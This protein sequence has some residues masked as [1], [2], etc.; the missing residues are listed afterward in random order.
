MILEFIARI[1]FSNRESVDKQ[2]QVLKDVN[3]EFFD[4][5]IYHVDS[6]PIQSVHVPIPF[7]GAPQAMALGPMVFPVDQVGY[8]KVGDRATVSS[9]DPMG[10]HL[11]R[12]ML[13]TVTAV[14]PVNLLIT[15]NIDTL[16]PDVGTYAPWWIGA[17]D[18]LTGQLQTIPQRTRFSVTAV[19]PQATADTGQ[20]LAKLTIILPQI[21]YNPYQS[22]STVWFDGLLFQ[23]STEAKTYFDGSG[24]PQPTNP[25]TDVFIS[26]KDTAWEIKD[27]INFIANSTF[28]STTSW[29]VN[30]ATLGNCFRPN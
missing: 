24:A 16:G 3:G 15:I 13:G 11:T 12:F 1:E 29:S 26:D 28:D 10:T 7:S 18:P 14:D 27:R 9:V 19:V 22:D 8:Y 17:T 6:A 5:T 4:P 23:D 30:N 25:I 20:P 2:A 21:Q